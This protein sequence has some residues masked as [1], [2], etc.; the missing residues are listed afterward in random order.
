MPLQEQD[1]LGRISDLRQEVSCRKNRIA[2][3]DH[4]IHSLNETISTL[5]KELELKGKEVLRVRSEANMHIRY[6]LI[7][8]CEDVW[9]FYEAVL[10]SRTYWTVSTQSSN[11]RSCFSFWSH[12]SIFPHH[13]LSFLSLSLSIKCQRGQK[14]KETGNV[15]AH[16]NT[17]MLRLEHKRWT[18]PLSWFLITS[19]YAKKTR[20]TDILCVC[21][22]F[23]GFH[24]LLYYTILKVSLAEPEANL[25][26]EESRRSY[27]PCRS[28]P[29]SGRAL[30]FS[31]ISVA[32]FCSDGINAS[33]SVGSVWQIY[34]NKFHLVLFKWAGFWLMKKYDILWGTE[35]ICSNK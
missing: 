31:I 12:S 21:R 11:R 19:F 33:R 13:L 28:P 32:F 16:S 25:M 3:L 34:T 9:T 1:L 15:R 4:E 27:F 18:M 22:I 5:T 26:W 10:T 24:E 7:N 20:A 30:W 29:P 23:F 17:F 35:G 2:D 14:H 6:Q 8:M